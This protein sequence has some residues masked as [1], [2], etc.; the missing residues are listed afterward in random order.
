MS[1]KKHMLRLSAKYGGNAAS[2]K[3]KQKETTQVFLLSE[4]P[5]KWSSFYAKKIGK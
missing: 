4:D 3:K 5:P 1:A 2:K